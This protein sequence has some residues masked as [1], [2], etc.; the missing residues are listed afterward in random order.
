MVFYLKTGPSGTGNV[1]QQVGPLMKLDVT[2]RQKQLYGASFGLHYQGM[3]MPLQF[4]F[5]SVKCFLYIKK[6][7]ALGSEAVRAFY[8]KFI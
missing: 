6:Y 2:S 5:I 1:S 3:F 4:K 7:I 8:L